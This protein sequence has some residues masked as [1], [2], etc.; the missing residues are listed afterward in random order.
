MDPRFNDIVDRPENKIFQVVFFPDRVYHAQYLNATR[1]VRYRYN[2][3]EV[4]GKADINV[5]KGEVYLDGI[6]LCN[7]LRI[8]YRGTRLGELSREKLRFLGPDILAEVG[9]Q[10]DDGWIWASVRM[11]YCPWIRAY[12]VEL[13]ET[14]EPPRNRRHDY[15]VLDLMG[16]GGSITR[17]PKFA[18]LLKGA[19]LKQIKRVKLAFRENDINYPSGATI[20]KGEVQWDNFFSRNIQVPNKPNEPS[21]PEN[22]VEDKNY[23]IYFQRGWFIK[24]VGQITPVKYV[25][26]M[27]EP[28]SRGF[29]E[30][31]QKNIIEMRWVFQQEFGGPVVFFHEVTIPPGTYEGVHQHIGSEELYFIVEGE[32]E[33]YL[34][35]DDDPSLADVKLEQDHIFG[36]GT[37]DVR[38]LDVGPRSVIFTKSGGIHGIRNKSKTKDLRFVAFL[39]HSA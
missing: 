21:S 32:G 16:F 34:G 19:D 25:N 13:W 1:S 6:K 27:M 10:K 28:P 29:D 30:T 5:L 38:V 26:G 36:I 39:Y 4:R 33:A 37:K 15:Q 31:K 12:Q 35:K 18:D 7:F 24:D 11:H 23:D 20:N 2:V 14:L 3:Q 17:E 8:E 9:I 22:T